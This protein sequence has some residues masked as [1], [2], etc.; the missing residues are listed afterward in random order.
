MAVVNQGFDVCG[1]GLGL[2]RPVQ[3]NSYPENYSAFGAMKHFRPKNLFYRT[4]DSRLQSFVENNWP[5]SMPQKPEQLA[6]AGFYYLGKFLF[7]QA[8]SLQLSSEPCK[9]KT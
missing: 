4:Y 8:P 6:E 5:P 7:I 9:L 3:R 2:G 1:N